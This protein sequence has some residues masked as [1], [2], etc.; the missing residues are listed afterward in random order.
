MMELTELTITKAA[1][2][3]ERREIS[4]VELAEAH[5][6]RIARVDP[7]LNCFITLTVQGAL[8]EARLAEAAIGEGNYLGP[9]HGIPLAVKDLYETAGVPTTAGST[10]FAEYVPE[11]DCAA[12]LKLKAAG[13]INLGKLN[14][15]EIALG[16]TNKNPHYGACRN[17]WQ[18]E[19]TPGGSSGGSGAALAAGLCL[20]SLGTDTGGSIRIP[21]SLSGVVGFKPT[22]GRVSTRGVIPLSWNLDHAG[23]MARRVR[24]VALLLQAIAGY[25]PEDPYS[26]DVPV[27]DTIGGLAEGVHGWRVAIASDAFFRR[28]EEEVLAAVNEAAKVLAASGAQVSEV[29]ISDG[30]AAALANGLMTTSDAAA[31]HQERLETQPEGFGEDVLQ[32]LQTGAGFSS[33]EYILARRTQTILRYQFERFF[34]DYDVLLTPSTPIPAPLLDGTDAVEQARKLT[35]F[36]APFNLTGLPALSLPCGFTRGGL[37]I[38]LQIVGPAWAE[39]RV[40]RAGYAY[41]RATDWHLRS[42]AL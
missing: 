31:F 35:R 28:A 18:L 11:E 1:E 30:R 39:A 2:M 4:P 19:R 10:F 15:H 42:P 6:A 21:A 7:Q 16:V 8:D 24:D 36:T 27:G 9:L 34:R 38:G 40:L 12:V 14:M 5:L 26:V 41:E 23:P 20:G 22:Y 33:T 29:E 37:P 13:A 25:D 32:R 3:I 17:P